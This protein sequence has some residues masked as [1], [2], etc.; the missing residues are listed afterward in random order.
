MQQQNNENFETKGDK[1]EIFISFS[2]QW[3]ANCYQ[4]WLVNNVCYTKT[5][6]HFYEPGDSDNPN[7]SVR[8]FKYPVKT[9][10]FV[11]M[12]FIVNSLRIQD[13]LIYRP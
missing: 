3:V 13:R 1:S 5:T 2:R 12:K 4:P 6:R 9:L 7:T 8:I 11:E 10:N